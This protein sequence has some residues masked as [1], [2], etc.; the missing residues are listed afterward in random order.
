[1]VMKNIKTYLNGIILAALSLVVFASDARSQSQLIRVEIPFEFSVND[2][3]LSA[4]TY[5]ISKESNG[6]L[7]VRP[8]FEGRAVAILPVASL[9]SLGRKAQPRVIFHRYGEDY[10]L[11]QVWLSFGDGRQLPKSK[12]ERLLSSELLLAKLNAKPISVE[13]V[14]LAR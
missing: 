13:I 6:A 8:D 12:T 5:T 10:F 4:G 14:S 1:M 2:R 3:N 7:I 9:S 11:R